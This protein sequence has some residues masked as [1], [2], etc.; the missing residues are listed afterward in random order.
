MLEEK[1]DLYIEEVREK[2]KDKSMDYNKL[3]AKCPFITNKK[4]LD[5]V[6]KKLEELDEDNLEFY[7]HIIDLIK[8]KNIDLN[9]LYLLYKEYND[10]EIIRD[11]LAEEIYNKEIELDTTKKN[12]NKDSDNVKEVEKTVKELKSMSGILDNLSKTISVDLDDMFVKIEREEAK[13]LGFG[14][15]ALLAIGSFLSFKNNKNIL[16]TVLVSYLSYKVISELASSSKNSYIDLCEEYITTLE[17]YKDDLE[18][19]EN[20]L[21]SNLDNIETL[22]KKLK[23]KYKAYLEE[24]EFKNLF[25]IIDKIK[26]SVKSSLKDVDKSLDNANRSIDESK[27]KVKR[28]EE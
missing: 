14:M 28:L 21:I 27:V 18:D 2:N 5:I 22:E 25:S 26:D 9:S 10:V 4:E 8:D 6:K 24:R 12:F 20:G 1:I 11:L 17:G 7:N 15:K 3:I 19:L 16:G 13:K 23:D